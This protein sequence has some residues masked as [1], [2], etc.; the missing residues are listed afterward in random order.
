MRE[1]LLSS[2]TDE[3]LCIHRPG[4]YT[5]VQGNM[6]PDELGHFGDWRF[7]F[8]AWDPKYGNIKNVNILLANI[9]EV[10]T[11]NVNDVVFLEWMKEEA[12]FIRAYSCNDLLQYNCVNI[13]YNDTI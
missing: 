1:D 10:P 9:D 12:H 8:L 4:G 11:E 3:T 2:A 5:F 6:S 7:S 13:L